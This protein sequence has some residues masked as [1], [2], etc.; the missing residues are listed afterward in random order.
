MPTHS[1]SRDA[2]DREVFR[3]VGILTVIW[4]ILLVVAGLALLFFG[5]QLFQLV[6]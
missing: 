5:D 6:S 3:R 2:N 1:D 4:V